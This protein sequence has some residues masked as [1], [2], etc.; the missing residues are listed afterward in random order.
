MARIS[1]TLLGGFQARL[2][3]DRVTVPTRKAEALL[4]YL[5]LH[6]GQSHPREKLATLLWGNS[7][8]TQARDSLRHA[9]VR[10][11]QALA[12]GPRPS[13]V[14]EGHVV[15]LSPA[16]VDVDVATFEQALA[17][18]A[19]E[20]AAALYRGDLLEGL[21]VT[22]TPFEDWLRAERA[23]LRELALETFAKLL[24]KQQATG[25]TERAIHTALRLL[26][27]DPLREVVHRE[28]MQLYA[29]QG[30]RGEALKQYEACATALRRELR[31]E[32]EA[33]TSRLY[34]ELGAR[35]V[36]AE[37]EDGGTGLALGDF[38][39][40]ETPLVGRE[41][42]MGRLRA[43]L[44]ES[45]A[46]RGSVVTILGEAGIGKSR[47]VDEVAAEALRS[48]SRVL[49]GRC[50]PS[51]QI[52]AFGVWV[53]ALRS[54][55]IG[56]DLARL[57]RLGPVWRAE[58][59]RL[60]PEVAR[61]DDRM[62]A[63]PADNLRLFEAVARLLGDLARHHPLLMLLEDL[64]W[65]DEM[66]LRL[67]AYLARRALG[68][69][70]LL[71]ATAREEEVA[72][73]PM[74][75]RTLEEVQLQRGAASLVLPPLSR[76]AV[77]S[78][79]HALTGSRAPVPFDAGLL[80]AVWVASGGHPLMAVETL[81]TAQERTGSPPA[82]A[83]G[84]IALPLSERVR[85]VIAGRLD[86]LSER[87]RRLAAVAAVIGREF[88]S[89]LLERAADL[90][91][92]EIADGLDE[93]VRRR[94]LRETRAGFDF[95]HDR[96]REVAYGQLLSPRRAFLHGQVLR[97]LETRYAED[98]LA[99]HYAAL[100]THARQAEAWDRALVY[101]REAGSQAAARAAHREA[102]TCFEQALDAAQHVPHGRELIEQT[103][104]LRIEL[105]KSLFPLGELAR[106]NEHLREGERL[107][108]SLGDQRRMARIAAYMGHSHWATGDTVR[109]ITL[110]EQ[111]LALAEALGDLS[112][113]A[114]A[115][116]FLGQGHHAHG[117][118]RR[119]IAVRSSQGLGCCKIPARCPIDT[120]S[121]NAEYPDR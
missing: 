31:T 8:E 3:A 107:A 71:V 72:D 66:S 80:E 53:D 55:R 47:L 88:D 85:Q 1:L 62:S 9:L 15:S 73:A 44:A 32:P 98:D 121:L 45:R 24:A 76:Q 5:A 22:E 119:A 30:R 117:D 74:L 34:R 101:L 118:Y 79:L 82:V 59:A 81:R 61:P 109:A 11:R 23:R 103:I 38:G 48:G 70:V 7:G 4:A 51:E 108:V 84:P 65:A 28:L 20:K 58:L 106:M 13:L 21:S 16:A 100:A 36:P 49:L 26:A 96:I 2:G 97:A 112:L 35:P 27:L 41:P 42:E 67:L 57:E 46:G 39:T 94:V 93:L 105:R 33:E 83:E 95:T 116:C 52:L 89:G 56:A 92:S 90:N 6:P 19:L 54:G 69:R 12:R 75:R 114:T 120:A 78:L 110:A 63:Q 113:K 17:A 102:A 68:W 18:G 10:L 115:S 14:T 37:E 40:P 29:Q 60:L 91:A 77:A 50:Y 87:S 43:A 86:R 111:G 64:H 25:A 99:P 104:D